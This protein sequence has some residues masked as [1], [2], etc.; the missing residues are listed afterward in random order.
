MKPFV[1]LASSFILA[2]AQVATAGDKGANQSSA[3]APAPARAA[4][5]APSVHRSGVSAPHNRWAGMPNGNIRRNYPGLAQPMHRNPL[6]V[7]TVTPQGTFRNH[8]ARRR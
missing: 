6:S 3:P 1:I 5:P 7:G 8:Q 4:A 2:V